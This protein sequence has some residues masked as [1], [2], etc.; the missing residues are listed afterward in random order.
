MTLG[1]DGPTG[2]GRKRRGGAPPLSW[3][4]AAIGALVIFAVGV[5]LG[6]ALAENPTGGGT[7]TQVRTL[8]PDTLP[9]ETVTVTV[10]VSG[11]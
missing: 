7:R 6:Q 3:V 2:A 11:P 5:G 10:G 4:L 9:P 8:V 1:L